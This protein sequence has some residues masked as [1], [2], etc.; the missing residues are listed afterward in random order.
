MN[1]APAAAESWDLKGLTLESMGGFHSS[2]QFFETFFCCHEYLVTYAQH[3]LRY[4][5]RSSC[6]V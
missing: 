5:S 3:E 2:Q 6:K 4:A 1:S